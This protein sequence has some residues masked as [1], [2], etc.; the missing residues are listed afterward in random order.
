MKFD[1]STVWSAIRYGIVGFLGLFVG[2][3]WVTPEFQEVVMGYWDEIAAAL[4][5]VTTAG[6]GVWSRYTLAKSKVVVVDESPL[7]RPVEPDWRI[8]E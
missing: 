1:M 6:F 3:E 5:A 2:R 4:A 7:G 8:D